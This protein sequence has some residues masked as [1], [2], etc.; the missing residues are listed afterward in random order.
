MEEEHFPYTAS[1]TDTL[2]LTNVT[3]AVV[4]EFSQINIPNVVLPALS[5]EERKWKVFAANYSFLQHN[6]TVPGGASISV[7]S[8]EGELLGFLSQPVILSL[9]VNNRT[10]NFANQSEAVITFPHNTQVSRSSLVKQQKAS[11]TKDS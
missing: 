4:S 10:Y 11:K 8:E 2:N 9:S 3:V 7:A 5:E 6:L 1:L